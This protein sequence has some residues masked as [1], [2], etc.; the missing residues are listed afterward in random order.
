MWAL[1][2]NNAVSGVPVLM[3][4]SSNC[5]GTTKGSQLMGLSQKLSIA[6]VQVIAAAC[7]V[8]AAL[9]VPIPAASAAM[10]V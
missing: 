3:D 8:C 7:A 9:K 4:T 1:D 6:P 5:P 10:A 2:P